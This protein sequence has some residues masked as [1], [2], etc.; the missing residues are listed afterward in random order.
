VIVHYM[1]KPDHDNEEEPVTPLAAPTEN[2]S[3]TETPTH[4]SAKK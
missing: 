2:K 3:A 4:P 1:V